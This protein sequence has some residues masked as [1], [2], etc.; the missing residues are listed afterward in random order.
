MKTNTPY[1][2]AYNRTSF[3]GACAHIRISAQCAYKCVVIYGFCEKDEK[4]RNIDMAINL[5]FDN[6]YTLPR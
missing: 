2:P 1:Y 5:I 3:N 6:A 4:T